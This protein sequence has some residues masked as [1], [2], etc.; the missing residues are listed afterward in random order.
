MLSFIVGAPIT[1]LKGLVYGQRKLLAFCCFLK[2][3]RSKYV[4]Y[5]SG[6]K[7]KI[8]LSLF[9]TVYTPLCSDTAVVIL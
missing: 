1:H 3:I 8:I 4:H 2:H 5:T 9:S 6:E 7:A